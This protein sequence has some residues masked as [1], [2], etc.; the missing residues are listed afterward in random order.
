MADFAAHAVRA[1]VDALIAHDAAAHPR[2]NGALVAADH[3]RDGRVVQGNPRLLEDDLV[4]ELLV[5]EPVSARLRLH[6][7]P[8]PGI[9]SHDVHAHLAACPAQQP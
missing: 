8:G 5:G 3:V 2:H 4:D 6:G 1:G 9:G 7:K